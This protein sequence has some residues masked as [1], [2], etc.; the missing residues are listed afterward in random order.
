[1]VERRGVFYYRQV[2]GDIDNRTVKDSFCSPSNVAKRAKRKLKG[3]VWKN[4][5]NSYNRKTDGTRTVG[6]FRGFVIYL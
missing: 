1:M 5:K 3:A 6:N 2:E 4:S